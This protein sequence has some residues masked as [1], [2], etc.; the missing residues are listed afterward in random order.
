MKFFIPISSFASAHWDSC[1]DAP[2]TPAPSGQ[3]CYLY[4]TSRNLLPRSGCLNTACPTSE[5]PAEDGAKCGLSTS[6]PTYSCSTKVGTLHE[7][8]RGLYSPHPSICEYFRYCISERLCRDSATEHRLSK[9]GNGISLPKLYVRLT[10]LPYGNRDDII[11][12]LKVKKF[13]QTIVAAINCGVLT[14]C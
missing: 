1:C 4:S 8:G 6:S 3:L 14:Y 13:I 9:H 10:N 7:G 2:N 11:P 12:Y 5:T